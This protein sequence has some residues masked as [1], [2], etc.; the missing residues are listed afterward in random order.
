MTQLAIDLAYRTAFGRADFLVSAC[1]ADALALVEHWPNWPASALLI[2]GPTGSGKTHLAHLWQAR[3][4]GMI[5]PA[6]TLDALEPVLQLAET[7]P[8]IAL[9]DADRAPE[10]PLLHLYNWCGERRTSLLLLSRLSPAAWTIGLPDLA[11]RVRSLPSVEIAAP[12]DRLLGAVLVKHFADRGLR[13]EPRVV[14]YAVRRME[15]SFDAAAALVGALDAAAMSNGSAVTI[16]L[17]RRVL[18]PTAV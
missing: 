10:A 4:G 12:D 2:H 5:V 8:G 11:S 18:A 3:C 17:A 7:S 9:D 6:A 1:N 14:A 13:V 15:R 16:A